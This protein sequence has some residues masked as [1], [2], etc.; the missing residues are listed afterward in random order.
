MKSFKT[1]EDFG[2]WSPKE[3]SDLSKAFSMFIKTSYSSF[4][5]LG[6]LLDL[7]Q[8][9]SFDFNFQAL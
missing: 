8:K 5:G 6:G 3:I 1:I 4:Y 9:L 2:E 7:D